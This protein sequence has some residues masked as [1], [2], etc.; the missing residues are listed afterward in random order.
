MLKRRDNVRNKA[1]ERTV[2]LIARQWLVSGKKAMWHGG[3]GEYDMMRETFGG[4]S[5][6]GDTQSIVTSRN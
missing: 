3:V 5:F 2:E 4:F 6:L 1:C